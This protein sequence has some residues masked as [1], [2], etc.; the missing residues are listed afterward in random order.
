M[1]QQSA[2][3]QIWRWCHRLTS[4]GAS[5]PPLAITSIVV[6]LGRSPRISAFGRHSTEA[7]EDAPASCVSARYLFTY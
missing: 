5:P 7:R 6:S 4:A 1:N 2:V 3:G